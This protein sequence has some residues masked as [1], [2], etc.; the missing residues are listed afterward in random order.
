MLLSSDRNFM[1]FDSPIAQPSGKVTYYGFINSS[2]T[3]AELI[4]A[5]VNL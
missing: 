2:H 5:A 3:L 4:A 1:P